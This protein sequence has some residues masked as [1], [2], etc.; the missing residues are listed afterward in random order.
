VS[1]ILISLGNSS[2]RQDAT[3]VLSASQPYE[4]ALAGCNALQETLWTPSNGTNIDFLP[5]LDFDK[6]TNNTGLHWIGSQSTSECRAMTTLGKIQAVTCETHL[7]ALCSQ[8]ASLSSPAS[9]DAGPRWQASIKTGNATIVGYRDKLSFRFLGLG[10]APRP[11]RFGYSK[12]Q[13]PS[14]NISALAYGA[15]CVQDDCEEPR[16]SEDCLSLNVWTPYL[17]TKNSSMPKKAV[18]FWIYG[19]GFTSGFGSDTTFDGGNMASRGDVVVVTINYRLSTLGFLALDNSTL[20]GNYWLSDQIAALDWVRA[21]IE[22]FGGD[23]DRITVFGQSA[24]GASVRALL[25][26]PLARGKFSRAILHSVPAGA[27]D[28]NLFSLYTPLSEAIT[29]ARSILNITSCAKPDVA[30]Q[31]ACLRA[32]DPMTLVDGR[33]GTNII[34]KCVQKPTKYFINAEGA[35]GLQ[36]WM[37]RI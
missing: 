21:H 11:M 3:I 24:G 31:V 2:T 19:G 20:R 15:G 27:G 23:K 16:C 13:A 9:T 18:M 32:L 12:Y 17:P 26:S 25:A 4:G 29:T 10:Y 36:S 5:Y 1:G 22:D 7:P 28:A 37:A 14:G 30:G 33:N 34:A 35:S 6:T 8:S